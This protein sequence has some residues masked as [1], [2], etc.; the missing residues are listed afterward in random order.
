MFS[1]FPLERKTIKKNCFSGKKL[2]HLDFVNMKRFYLILLFLLAL[3]TLVKSQ[4]CGF[5]GNDT[6]VCSNTFK[7]NASSVIASATIQWTCIDRPLGAALP[8]FD[9]P[10][11]LQPTVTIDEN[12]GF[13]TFVFSETTILNS[14]KDTIVV[15]FVEAPVTLFSMTPIY[16]F[17]EPLII[18]YLG[19]PSAYSSGSYI[20]NFDG[21]E[22]VSGS[23]AGPYQLEWSEGGSYDVSLKINIGECISEE[24]LRTVVIPKKLTNTIIKEDAYCNTCNGEIN[25]ST[26]GGYTPYHYMLNGVNSNQYVTDL[27]AGSYQLSTID[28]NNCELISDI[29]IENKGAFSVITSMSDTICRGQGATLQAEVISRNPDNEY[30]FFWRDTY[31][32]TTDT[33]IWEV[34]PNVSNTYYLTVTDV[35]T[36][37]TIVPDPVTITVG[38]LP[39][40][41]FSMEPPIITAEC[42]SINFRNSSVNATK[43]Y[44]DFG[45]G[46]NS[47]SAIPSHEFDMMKEKY[48]VCLTAE[49]EFNCYYTICQ[50]IPVYKFIEFY[51]PTAFTPND[52][53]IND[54]FR[55]C[56][57]LI[58]AKTFSMK[59]FDR[60]GNIVFSTNEYFYDDIEPD[61]SSCEEQP[62]AWNGKRH[63]TGEVLPSGSYF[64]NLSFVGKDGLTYSKSGIVTLLR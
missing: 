14:C 56:G 17:G 6:I 11:L 36:G 51:V 5:A 57:E 60:W 34:T 1:D 54:C 53:E 15:K 38:T 39:E 32:V 18:S 29:T 13:Y 23:G 10:N 37:C 30:T 44:W 31:G 22:I 61:C 33:N 7:F 47:S 21:A 35:E 2:L 59:V 16:C 27:C 58:D 20:W 64:W 43:Y 19:D 55:P 28:S 48:T 8:V 49:N 42:P 45:D 4:P 63:N 50:D 3:G 9:N 46:E 12:Y 62:G 25:V 41:R 40:A 26:E 52:D 24:N